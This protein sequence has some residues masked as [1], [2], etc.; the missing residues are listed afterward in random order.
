MG[1]VESLCP[2]GF[3]RISKSMG[4]YP[5]SYLNRANFY[6]KNGS[7]YDETVLKIKI[8]KPKN[9]RN[10]SFLFNK[11]EPKNLKMCTI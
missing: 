2:Q 8:F 11:L 3:A 7:I 4:S 5:S 1:V 9:F 10:Q 6:I